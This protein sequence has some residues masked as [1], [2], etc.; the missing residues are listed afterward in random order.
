MDD[1]EKALILAS[2][3]INNNKNKKNYV[4]DLR[5]LDKIVLS[6]E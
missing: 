3:V 5:I 1:F 6:D 2:Q 4:I